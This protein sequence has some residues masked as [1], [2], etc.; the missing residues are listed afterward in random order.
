MNLKDT[1]LNETGQIPPDSTY[2][3][4]LAWQVHRDKKQSRRWEEQDKELLF[5]GY[6][7]SVWNDE[8]VLELVVMVGRTLW[9]YRCHVIAYLKMIKMVNFLLCILTLATKK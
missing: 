3:W 2:M 1:M 7:I 8:K 5:K 4:S 9:E 6:R